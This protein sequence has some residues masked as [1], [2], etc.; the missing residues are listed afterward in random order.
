MKFIRISWLPLLMAAAPAQQAPNILPPS[1]P[2]IRTTVEEVLLDVV[3]RDKKDKQVRELGPGDFEVLDNGAK[4][5][6]RSVRLVEGREAISKGAAAGA[7][8]AVALD[9]LRQ[10]R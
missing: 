1:Q 4:Q 3:V 7:P 8:A 10:I 9:P 2:A 6:I 5:T